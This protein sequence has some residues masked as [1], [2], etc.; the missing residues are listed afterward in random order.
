MNAISHLV[1]S[2]SALDDFRDWDFSFTG[3]FEYI[4]NL[5]KYHIAQQGIPGVIAIVVI[6]LGMLIAYPPTR[7]LG[8]QLSTNLIQSVFSIINVLTMGLGLLIVAGASRLGSGAVR[9]FGRSLID[10]AKSKK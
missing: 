9:N 1:I 5:I 8:S 10:W 7:Y 2:A 4:W 3:V 6:I